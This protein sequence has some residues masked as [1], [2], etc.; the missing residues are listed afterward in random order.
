MMPWSGLEDR[1]GGDTIN[2]NMEC[3]KRRA[4]FRKKY[5]KHSFK[6]VE[7]SKYLLESI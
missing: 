7:S 2:G 1:L 3:K 6:H 5:N 4:T